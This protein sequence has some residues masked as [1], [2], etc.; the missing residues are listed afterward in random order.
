MLIADKAFKLGILALCCSLSIIF[1]PIGFLIG[2]L[3]L[4]KATQGFTLIENRPKRRKINRKLW[5]AV[6]F[7]GFALL[8]I[9]ALIALLVAF[10][11]SYSGF[12]LDFSGGSWWSPF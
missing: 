11:K 5:L 12:D 9:L 8:P 7:G 1:S 4:A 6:V 2:I 10:Q 3:A